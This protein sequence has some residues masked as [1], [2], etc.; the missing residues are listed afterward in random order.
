MEF[1][2]HNS[3][4]NANMGELSH[5]QKAFP[6]L[7]QNGE[8]VLEHCCRDNIWCIEWCPPKLNVQCSALQKETKKI[9]QGE[10]HF[11]ENKPWDS[12][13]LLYW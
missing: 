8:E 12:F 4:P 1:T 11:K 6:V 10:N 13:S 2:S 9:L 5:L 7:T 3:I